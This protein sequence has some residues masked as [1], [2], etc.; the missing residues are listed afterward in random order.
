LLLWAQESAGEGGKG[1]D[2]VGKWSQRWHDNCN[3]TIVMLSSSPHC[4][5]RCGPCWGVRE[6]ARTWERAR[7]R[8]RQGRAGET[9]MP[10]VREMAR[11]SSSEQ[12]CKRTQTCCLCM[13]V[14]S[15]A[16]GGVGG[17]PRARMTQWGHEGSEGESERMHGSVHMHANSLS[18]C[19][20]TLA[21]MWRPGE[22]E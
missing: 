18:A 16:C 13:C 8:V 3:N 14:H 7:A 1:W 4:C 15:E 12:V 21:G 5:H 9:D 6:R 11:V 22:S 19:V 10:N 2:K 17:W 20:H